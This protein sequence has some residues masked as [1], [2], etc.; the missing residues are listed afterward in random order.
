[1]TWWVYIVQATNGFLYT[2]IATDPK[3]RF[4]EHCEGKKGAKFF[5]RSQPQKIVYL[6]Q[7]DSRSLATSREIAIKKLSRAQKLR[8]IA[9]YEKPTHS[10]S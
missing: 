3:R 6:E 1:L 10:L 5:R 2:G 9:S 4:K 8:L 7:H